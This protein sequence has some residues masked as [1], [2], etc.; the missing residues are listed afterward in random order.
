M[1]LG[2][3]QKFG[4]IGEGQQAKIVQGIHLITS[5]TDGSR[6]L[7]FSRWFREVG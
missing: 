6:P 2:T 4:D 5:S 3:V 1:R 7:N